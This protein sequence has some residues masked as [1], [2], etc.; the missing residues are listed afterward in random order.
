MGKMGNLGKGY[1]WG[2]TGR[3]VVSGVK[4]GKIGCGAS[5][6]FLGILWESGLLA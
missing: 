6:A 1:G 2:L 4:S 3:E 5:W